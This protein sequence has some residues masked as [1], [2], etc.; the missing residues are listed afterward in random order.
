[1]SKPSFFFG[2]IP[3]V[4]GLFI[5]AFALHAT[6][7]AA[8]DQHP[9][10]VFDRYAPV[11]S[12]PNN[13]HL[14]L[15]FGEYDFVNG[16]QLYVP[17]SKGLTKEWLEARVRRALADAED[18]AY[19]AHSSDAACPSLPGS[20][21]D[22]DVTVTSVGPGFWVQLIAHDQASIDALRHWAQRY[23]H[24][25]HGGHGVHGVHRVHD[26]HA[27]KLRSVRGRAQASAG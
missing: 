18:P 7:A 27:G 12:A 16:T 3:A 22:V 1:M 26:V 5:G 14:Y 25:G 4:L 10:C 23:V 17:A 9:S 8:A 20:L 19:L 15:P 24:G 13:Q 6:P 21:K 2:G 11:A